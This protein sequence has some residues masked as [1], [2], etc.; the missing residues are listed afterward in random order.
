MG[1]AASL[2]A[3]YT[4]SGRMLGFV[5]DYLRDVVYP[6]YANTHTEASATG[7]QTTVLREEARAIISTAMNAPTEDY[8]TLFVGTGCTGAIDKLTS[9]DHSYGCGPGGL[10]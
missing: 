9:I 6:L 10:F 8:V 1:T 2:Y 5:E 4:A 3:D 7:F